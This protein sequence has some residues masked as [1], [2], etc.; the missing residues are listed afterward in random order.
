MRPGRYDAA[1]MS[2]TEASAR[3]SVVRGREDIARELQPLQAS[4][5]KIVCFLYVGQLLFQ[6]R[7]AEVDPA[8]GHVAFEGIADEK[9]AAALLVQ[10]RCTF[11]ATVDGWRIEFVAAGPRREAAS[12]R[13]DFPDVLTRWKRA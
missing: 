8:A 11:S 13:V 2:T 10:P 5:E 1:E 3:A 4:G 6:S 12:I 9:A 7:L